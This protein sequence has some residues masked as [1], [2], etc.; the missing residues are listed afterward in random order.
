MLGHRHL[1]VYLSKLADVPNPLALQGAEISGDAAVFEVDNP[2]EWFIKERPDRE[3]WKVPSF[4]LVQILD[5]IS[6]M[7]Q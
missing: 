6:D 7:V 2:S 3:N 5:I 4:G 1:F